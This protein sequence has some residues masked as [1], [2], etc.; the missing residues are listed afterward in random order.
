MPHEQSE[1]NEQRVPTG[2]EKLV[3]CLEREGVKYIFGLSG[4]AAM[5][6]FDALVDSPIQL[7]LVRHEQGATHMA[8][9][10]ARSTGKPGRGAGDLRPRGDQHRD[11]PAD[12]ADGLLAGDR[13]QRPA[14]PAGA[15]QGRLPGGGRHRH[16]V[17]GR[18][19]LLS[20]EERQR[21]PAHRARGLPRGD[22]RPPRPGADR[23]A[24]GHRPGP[25]PGT[26]HRPGRPARLSASRCAASPR[27]SPRPPGCCARHA[28]RCSTSGTAP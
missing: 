19:A 28:G 6:I 22:H 2:G 25:L 23:R 10:Y 12:G 17:P 11:R 14:D 24:Q 8:D 27:A 5:P 21:H 18:E 26:V 20:G 4:G 16:H 15:R 1:P 13:D 3:Q 7:I 9:G